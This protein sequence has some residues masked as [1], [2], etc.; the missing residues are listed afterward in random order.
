VFDHTS[1]IRFVQARFG[2]TA[3]PLTDSNITPW[4]SAVCGDLISAFNFATPEE[5][6]VKLPST[7]AYVPPN[8]NRQTVSYIPLPPLIQTM[9]RQETGTRPARPVPYRINTTASANLTTEMVA[10]TFTN[11]G[12]QAAVFQVRSANPLQAPRSYT[13]GAEATLSDSWEFATAGLAAYDLS[14]YGPNG[15][16]RHYR[17]GLAIPTATNLASRIAY[18]PSANSV[19]V[20]VQNAGASTVTVL[21]E[22]AYGGAVVGKELGAGDSFDTTVSVADHAGWYDFIVTAESDDTFQ[23]QLAGHLETGKPSA[24]DPAI[25]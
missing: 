14:V 16:Y 21:I 25:S 12:S 18:D 24:T 1:L 7:A 4:R 5:A 17:G 20:S 19:T 13:V 3:A 10:M 11:V 15:F 22:N 8:S 2:T 6:A 9:P 23:Q